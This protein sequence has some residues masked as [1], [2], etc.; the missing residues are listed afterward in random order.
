MP[1]REWDEIIYPFLNFNADVLEWQS[2]YNPQ[3]M[4]SEQYIDVGIKLHPI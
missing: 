1:G 3:F 4:M 2:K